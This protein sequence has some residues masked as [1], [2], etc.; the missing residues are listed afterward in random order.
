[1][2]IKRMPWFRYHPRD[3]RANP[4]LKL[5]SRAARC[6]WLELRG[7][8]HEAEPYGYL[9]IEGQQPTLEDLATVLGGVAA[10]LEPLMAELIA[11]RVVDHS[12]AGVPCCYDMIS[13]RAKDIQASIDGKS[14]GNP[15]L[16]KGGV[17]PPHKGRVKPRRQTSP[18]GKKSDD[19]ERG[20]LAAP[21][22]TVVQDWTT[23]RPKWAAFR[24][25]VL[26]AYLGEK[27]WGHWFADA[28]LGDAENILVVPSRFAVDK[29]RESFGDLLARHVGEVL[30]QIDKK[31]VAQ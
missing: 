25:A 21:A 17:N 22:L 28:R 11:R 26:A 23:G 27:A 29:I 8:M 16:K 10:E 12:P 4:K 13:Q 1:M 30:F 9:L 5:L 19:S 2:T 20:A 31:A 14:G 3:E 7:L 18:T 6:F 15:A 24:E